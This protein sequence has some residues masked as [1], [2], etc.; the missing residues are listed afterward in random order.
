MKT[1]S[2]LLL[3]TKSSKSPE[4]GFRK[5]NF[6]F[7]HLSAADQMGHTKKPDSEAYTAMVHNLDT[8]IARV[9][10]IFR[11]YPKIAQETAFILTSDHGMTDWGRF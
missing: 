4:D 7:L 1:H 11:E 6:I 2:Y 3:N 5:G 10:A 8:N 9:L